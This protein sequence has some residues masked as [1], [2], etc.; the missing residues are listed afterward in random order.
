MAIFELIMANLFVQE[1]FKSPEEASLCS[2]ALGQHI[3]LNQ[4]VYACY[5]CNPVEDGDQPLCC[6]KS[7][8]QKCHNG[9]EVSFLAQGKAFCDCFQRQNCCKL[10]NESIEKC[11]KL[12]SA[13]GTCCGSLDSEVNSASPIEFMDLHFSPVLGG[14]EGVYFAN[15]I[16]EMCKALVKESK[17]TFWIS[18]H[19]QARCPLEALALDIY[20][21]H[22]GRFG[23]AS[24][25]HS[26]AEWWVQVKEFVSCNE[27]EELPLKA[28]APGVDLHYD[29][30][31][32]VAEAFEI[33]LY[34]DISTVTY[35]TDVPGSAP[36]ALFLKTAEEDVDA[37]IWKSAVVHPRLG[38]H[39]S[40]NGKL[41][42]GA[43]GMLSSV[44]QMA[45]DR[46]MHFRVTFLVNVWRHHKPVGVSILPAEILSSI[47]NSLTAAA[48]TNLTDMSLHLKPDDS[49]V[50]AITIHSQMLPNV[51]ASVENTNTCSL[52]SHIIPFLSENVDWQK[53]ED[54]SGLSLALWLPKACQDVQSGDY[55]KTTFIVSYSDETC[56][57]FL[58]GEDEE[59]EEEEDEEE[60]EEKEA[61]LNGI[62]GTAA[63]SKEQD[64]QGDYEEE[65]DE[66]GDYEEEQDEQGEEEEDV[67]DRMTAAF[68]KVSDI[69]NDIMRRIS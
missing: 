66:Q 63:A 27:N 64:E 67:V 49:S 31:E 13:G 9:H 4:P 37:P 54:E 6:C 41:L 51:N 23:L 35:L 42:H 56:A 2:F 44:A 29:K 68:Y 22:M 60:A 16:V 19:A 12:L 26:G 21:Y 7:C 38:K 8:V 40:F 46:Q 32:V 48:L 61:T 43:P 59:E 47:N 14:D 39:I 45:C 69:S 11:S 17:E 20:Q 1:D 36:T 50:N 52:V 57:A 18:A 3:M 62:F 15:D 25:A 33:G 58:V 24:K 65:Q 53:G 5:T 10:V 30:D 34:P 55:S 28:S